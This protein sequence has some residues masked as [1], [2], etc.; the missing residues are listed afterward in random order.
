MIKRKQLRAWAQESAAAL[1]RWGWTE[2]DRI[3]NQVIVDVYRHDIPIKQSVEYR[4][5]VLALVSKV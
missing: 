4:D 5:L 1:K 3:I 2:Q